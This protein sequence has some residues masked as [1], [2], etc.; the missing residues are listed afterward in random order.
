MPAKLEIVSQNRCF[1]GSVI[2]YEHQ[3]EVLKCTMRFNVYLPDS[4]EPLPVLYFLSGLTCT[5]DNFI[6]KAGALRYLSDK[7]I[8]LVC[9]DTSPRGVTITGQDD[10]WDFGSGAGFYVDATE[11]P[12]SAHYQMYSYVIRELPGLIHAHLA[13][14]PDRA[15]IMGH[16]MGGHGALIS[17]LKNPGRYRSVSVLAAIC[18][19]T[20]C[21]WGIKAFS[22][23]LGATNRSCWEAYDATELARF[24]R[25]P[26]LP[27]LLDQGDQ[28]AFLK[29]KQL[30]PQ[31][32]LLAAENGPGRQQLAIENRMRPGFDHSYFYIQTFIEDHIQFH[33]RHLLEASD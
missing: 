31:H 12:W 5:E 30:L 7:K 4:K 24:Y 1:E 18:H 15:S 8:A 10:A 11:A 21:P 14:D 33:A 6:Q 20:Q 25:G 9:P 29:Q 13:V 16:S 3:S 23:Y 2:K 32:F 26:Q 28:D 19:P 17:A 27:I 22:G